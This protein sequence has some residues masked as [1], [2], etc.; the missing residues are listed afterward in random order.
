[1]QLCIALCLVLFI[2]K[3]NI[4]KINTNIM[5]I[6]IFFLGAPSVGKSTLAHGL[7]YWLGKH[8]HL[9]TGFI[10]ESAKELTWKRHI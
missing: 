5:T 10:E 1:V 8:L 7:M 9:S 6:N 3:I 2:Y 4:I